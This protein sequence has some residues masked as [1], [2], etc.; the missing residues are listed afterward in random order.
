MDR[1]TFDGNFCDIARCVG[2]P[3]NTSECPGGYCDQRRTWERLKRYE[4][5][6]EA[7][8]L[9]RLRAGIGDTVY[10]VIGGRIV[11]MEIQYIYVS[12]KGRTRY[13]AKEAVLEKNFRDPAFGRD[14]FLTEAAAERAVRNAE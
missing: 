10:A 4:D 11:P 2:E 6:E 3:G 1:L 13:H 5:M 14:V 12:R 7:G 9:V 8:R